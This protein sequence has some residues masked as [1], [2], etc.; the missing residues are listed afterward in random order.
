[1]GV[2]I[3]PGSAAALRIR[4]G[5]GSIYEK[6]IFELRIEGLWNWFRSLGL[7]DSS[8][9]QIVKSS[10][11]RIVKPSNR[12]CSSKLKAESSKQNPLD[13]ESVG[14]AELVDGLT[15]KKLGS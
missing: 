1:M 13:F 2:A 6:R 11:L 10:N 12:E 4:M 8:N 5:F 14:L 3:S 7:V 9:R 15:G